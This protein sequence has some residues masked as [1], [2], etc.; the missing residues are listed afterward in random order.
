MK[1]LKVAPDDILIGG[2]HKRMI[3]VT[4]KLVANGFEV[5]FLVAKSEGAR[6]RRYRLDRTP[7][8]Q[9]RSPKA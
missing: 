6:P 8:L 1:I 7:V 3:I 4:K 9:G 5:D 2:V